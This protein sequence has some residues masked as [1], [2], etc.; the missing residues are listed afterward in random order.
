M[1]FEDFFRLALGQDI[2][3]YPYQKSLSQQ[4]WPDILD[5]YTGLGKTASIII[6]WL[7]KRHNGDTVTPRRLVYCLPMRVLVEQTSSNAVQWISNL[8]TQKVYSEATR[9]TVH[10][11]MG[12]ELDQD[13][14]FTPEQDQ[15]LIGTQDQLLSRALNRGYSMS[16]F[17]WP[18]H[19]GLL[20]NDCLWVM[21]EVQLMGEGLATTVQLQ[22]FRDA[23]KT[24]YPVRSV[25]MSATLRQS[26]LDT[27]DFSPCLDSLRSYS[28]GETDR[29]HEAVKRRT[30]AS[31]AVEQA[32]CQS[33][34]PKELA[35]FTLEHHQPKTRTLV[36]LNTVKRAQDL[37][38]EIKKKKP[39]CELY[40]IHSR[41]RPQDRSRAIDKL[42]SPPGQHGSICV[43]TQVIEAGVD[44][45]SCTMITDLAPWASLIQRFGRCNR[46][47][48]ETDANIYWLDLDLSKKGQA[49]PYKP[50]NLQKARH[51]LEG[52]TNAKPANLPRLDDD[53][54]Y[55]H[56]I[57]K[58]DL[59]D[60][61]DTTPDLAGSDI[62]VSRFVRETD[63]HSLQVFWREFGDDGPSSQEPAPARDELCSVSIA[64][65]AGVSDLSKWRWDHLEKRWQRIWRNDELYPGLTILLDANEGCYDAEMGWTGNKKDVPEVLPRPEK[66]LEAYDDDMITSTGWQT[67]SDHI[68]AVVFELELLLSSLDLVD[69]KIR[70]AI[71][72]AAHWHDAG[73]SHPVFQEA[74]TKDSDPPEENTMW[75]KTAKKGVK[76]SRRGFRHELASGLV[77]I[78]N[79]LPDLAVYLAAAHHGKVRLSIRSLPNE[80]RPEKPDIRFARGIW[81]GDKLPETVL[82]N[83]TV[84]PETKIS[85]SPMELGEGPKGKSWLSRM[86][87]L[88]DDPHIGPFKLA[89]LEALLRIADWRASMNQG[90][91]HA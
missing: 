57:R 49:A 33:S 83:G 47:G 90:V 67:L 42:L 62:D 55:L 38:Q 70:N 81:D 65:L 19:F 40:L 5:I 77:M 35:Q 4:D 75:G 21:D 87:N 29:E 22:A 26:W 52:L 23:F 44:V 9:P 41:F 34:N 71:K 12:G 86:L 13:W 61:F 48:L 73:K 78:E 10:V 69:P 39:E 11:L 51:I 56:V 91:D 85:L 16:R 36:V 7:Y 43:T 20:N 66:L 46:D 37:Y 89:Y 24:I 54:K 30:E 53:P 32:P 18:I 64:S 8:T 76:Y 45:S 15:I 27:V 82:G 2:Q 79:G 63:D 6:A 17:R 1:G 25:W 84:M 58:K 59:I 3:P 31:K 74:M 50:Q 68:E 14:D 72:L 60:L 88:R 28:L 80:T